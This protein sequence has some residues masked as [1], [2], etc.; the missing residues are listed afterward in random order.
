MGITNA[1]LAVSS[2][3][4]IDTGS[5]TAFSYLEVG[6]GST[7]FVATQTALVT[8]VT[9]SGLARAAGTK[10]RVTTTA[11]NDTSQL[12]KQ[13]NVTGSKTLAEQGTFNASSGG[14]MLQRTVLSPTRS[15]VNGDTYTLTVKVAHA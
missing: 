11:T 14:V 4:L 15:V 8:A 10:S 9:D 2:G 7:A 5:Q 3:L 1:A 13:W 12:S 6:T